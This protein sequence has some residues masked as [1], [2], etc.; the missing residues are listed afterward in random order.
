MAS[1]KFNKV[2]YFMKFVQRLQVVFK[3]LYT[4]SPFISF[5][6][7]WSRA[8]RSYALPFGEY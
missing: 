5:C 4:A 3:L 8:Y 7:S 6:L 1:A 2:T